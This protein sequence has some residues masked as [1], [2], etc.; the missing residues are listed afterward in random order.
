MNNEGLIVKLKEYLQEVLSR[1][2]T[3]L[4][5][6]NISIYAQ[7]KVGTFFEE[8]TYKDFVNELQTQIKK[9]CDSLSEL[10]SQRADALK[11]I[12]K[13]VPLCDSRELKRL[14]VSIDDKEKQVSAA[15][16]QLKNQFGFNWWSI[17]AK[18]QGCEDAK[19]RSE[20]HEAKRRSEEHK[21]ECMR[22][23]LDSLRRKRASLYERHR[24]LDK[25][26]AKVNRFI[27][28][29][30]PTTAHLEELQTRLFKCEILFPLYLRTKQSLKELYSVGII[31]PKYHNIVAI[32]S[33]Y[34]SIDTDVALFK[35]QGRFEY[36]LPAAYHEYNEDLR[37]NRIVDAQSSTLGAIITGFK[38]L[39][40]QLAQQ[41]NT[42]SELLNQQ[43]NAI[44][45]NQHALYF[46]IQQGNSLLENIADKFSDLS[47]EV[48]NISGAISSIGNTVSLAQYQTEN[49]SNF[50]RDNAQTMLQ[51]TQ[52]Q[53]IKLDE[54]TCIQQ[55]INANARILDLVHRDHW[56]NLRNYAGERI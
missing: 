53:G 34:E 46:A 48:S 31:H 37:T 33:I 12:A 4:A 17:Q 43:F 20:E 11:E 10:S 8:N 38:S 47:F 1:E 49:F 32:A 30:N 52:Y 3:I 23:E 5:L 29:F 24:S 36:I 41:T 55:E 35:A 19:R 25:E 18:S 21:I 13:L 39:S 40:A 28:N 7:M 44:K 15:R 54:I 2:S 27:D 45:K 51:H 9:T 22:I 16:E 26:K 6:S 56:G 14:S 42:L 50:Q